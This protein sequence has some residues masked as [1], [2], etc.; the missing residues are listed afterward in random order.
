MK[1]TVPAEL[2]G[3]RLDVALARLLPGWSRTRLKPLI[4]AGGVRV[5]GDVAERA[6][7][8]VQA[9]DDLELELPDTPH[10]KSPSGEEIVALRVI[11]EDE[12]VVVIDKPAGLLSHANAPHQQKSVAELAVERYGDLPG[13]D[14]PGIVHRLDRLTSGVMLVA[15]TAEALEGLQAQFRERTVEKTYLAVVYGDPRFDSDWIEKPVGRDERH[16][17]RFRVAADGREAVTYYEVRERLAGFAIIEA[18]PKTGR[19]HQIRV[20]LAAAELPIVG[21]RLYTRGVPPLKV[22]V[23]RQLLHAASIA[24]THPVS[25]ERLRFEVDAPGDFQEFLK[26][27]RIG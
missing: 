11:H 19:T 2:D 15:R 10:A 20:H 23:R 24:F 7:L 21:D 16:P 27:V 17:E 13:E 5:A 25:G 3:A 14:R 6:N 26:A 8:V 9:G 4:T 22:K 1:V 18:F 12:H